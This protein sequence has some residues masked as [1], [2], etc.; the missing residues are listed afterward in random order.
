MSAQPWEFQ[1]PLCSEV[2]L[3]VFFENKEDVTA[4][5][6]DKENSALAIKIC[7]SCI[8]IGECL[9]WAVKHEMF[10][11]WGGTTPQQRQELRKRKKLIVDTELKTIG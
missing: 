7:N 3:E 1:S 8:H 10:G 9:D 2:G 4:S 5:K 11:V 6:N